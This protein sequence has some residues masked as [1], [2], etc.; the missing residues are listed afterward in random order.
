MMS[1]GR[2]EERDLFVR[3]CVRGWCYFGVVF[4]GGAIGKEGGVE[5]QLSWGRC[6]GWLVARPAASG[7]QG[8]GSLGG[9]VR[10]V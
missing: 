9:R 8:C 2:G 5:H 4:G 7:W 3:G 1:S 10:E 6:W